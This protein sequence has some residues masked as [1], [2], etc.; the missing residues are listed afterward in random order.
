MPR[1]EARRPHRL[2]PRR[3]ASVGRFRRQGID[4]GPRQGPRPVVVASSGSTAHADPCRSPWVRALNVPPPASPLP[5][6][7]RLDFGRRVRRYAHPVGPACSGLHF[8]SVLRCASGFFPT[9]PHGA[10]TGVSRRH[11]LRAVASGSWLLPTRPAR[12]PANAVTKQAQNTG[13]TPCL[14]RTGIYYSRQSLSEDGLPAFSVPTLPSTNRQRDPY[15][16]VR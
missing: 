12:P 3:P 11:S 5:L 6:R 2:S 4:A 15:R 16:P 1:R 9:R 13:R 14:T 10:R 7:P 8:R